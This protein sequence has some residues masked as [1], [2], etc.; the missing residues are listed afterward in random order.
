MQHLYNKND[1]DY[2]RFGGFTPLKLN[3]T[4]TV[5]PRYND[6]PRDRSNGGR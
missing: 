5:E 3:E 2:Y 1:K 4:T 6:H